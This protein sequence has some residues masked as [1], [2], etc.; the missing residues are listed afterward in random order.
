[1]EIKKFKGILTEWKSIMPGYCG[2]MRMYYRGKAWYPAWFSEDRS[3]DMFTAEAQTEANG[4]CRELAEHWPGGCNDQMRRDVKTYNAEIGGS[5][6]RY[7]LETESNDFKFLI[8]IDT[9]YGNSDYPIRVHTYRKGY[10]QDEP[11]EGLEGNTRDCGLEDWQLT[12]SEA[13][14]IV[15]RIKEGTYELYRAEAVGLIDDKEGLFNIA[16]AFIHIKEINLEEVFINYGYNTLEELKKDYCN[17]WE[18]YLAECCFELNV[19]KYLLPSEGLTFTAAVDRIL[20]MSGYQLRNP[21]DNDKFIQFMVKVQKHDV[22]Y[23][24]FQYMQGRSG[25]IMTSDRE[26]KSVSYLI[27][28]KEGLDKLITEY[29]LPLRICDVCGSVMNSGWT[30]E[31]GETY[32]CK[33]E[34]FSADMD[35]RYGAENW[36]LEPTGNFE[37]SYEYR[38]DI[39]SPWLP[40]P[41][42]Y[43]DWE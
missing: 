26:Y 8:Y 11:L 24:H 28:S 2:Y 31:F 20:N 19:K 30:D 41:S 14:Q 10:T 9:R 40:E 6:G 17:G 22:G 12:N 42:Y 1:M 13:C 35:E 29:D 23:F 5:R 18:S 43:T 4:L 16:H 21:V 32:F 33:K 37:W 7:L 15:R 27:F 39:N 36:R 3:T 38:K 34:E 25:V